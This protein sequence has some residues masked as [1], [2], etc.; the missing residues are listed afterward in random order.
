MAG[1][2]NEYCSYH[3]GRAEEELALAQN[4]TSLEAV[5][6]HATLAEL[7]LRIVYDQASER[8]GEGNALLGGS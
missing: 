1:M 8:D 5:K 4:A 7:H 3:E 6:A 2:K